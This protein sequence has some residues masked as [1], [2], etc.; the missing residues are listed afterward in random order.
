MFRYGV[1]VEGHFFHAKFDFG[2][3]DLYASLRAAAYE[4]LV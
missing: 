4:G 1:I 2:G 3:F